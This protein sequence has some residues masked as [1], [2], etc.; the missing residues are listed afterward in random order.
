VEV[1]LVVEPHL[2]VESHVVVLVVEPHP[3]VESHVEVVIPQIAEYLL[4]ELEILADLVV[5]VEVLVEY[6]M[7]LVVEVVEVDCHPM[8]VT[9]HLRIIPP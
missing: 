7:F 2:L 9:Y 4:K 5:E 6:L 3:L 1:V 8:M